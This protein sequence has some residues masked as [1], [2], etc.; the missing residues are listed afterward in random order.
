MRPTTIYWT[1][2]DGWRQARAMERG[3]TIPTEAHRDLAPSEIAA[4]PED[5][6][7]LLVRGGTV[8]TGPIHYVEIRRDGTLLLRGEGYSPSRG[9]YWTAPLA[10]DGD[11]LQADALVGV[12]R[13]A[14]AEAQ[15]LRARELPAIEAAE[16]EEEGAAAAYAGALRAYWRRRA[17]GEAY[18]AV[19]FPDSPAA[20]PCRRAEDLRSEA[21]AS[22]DARSVEERDE[23]QKAEREAAKERERL[24][25][26]EAHGSPRL[27]A[28][29]REGIEYERVYRDERLAAERPGWMWE[30][31]L[32]G[33]AE[34]AHG[35]SVTDEH[36]A[37]L[38][39]A[40]Q[41]EPAAQLRWLGDGDHTDGCDCA[42]GEVVQ[43]MILCAEEY[44]GR[45]IVREIE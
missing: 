6:R 10:Y 30:S 25:W 28:L 32:C 2:S 42:Q 35:P 44:L 40:R 36:L 26:I 16:R 43:R 45:K 5:L 37:A 13:T 14:I 8:Q 29:V 38:E 27:R 31:M 11:D 9:H 19:A 39:A 21:F 20:L 23:R 7:G 17:T 24:A 3:Q 22:E 33:A 34:A 4:L 41:V 12:L 18:E 15:Q 1:R